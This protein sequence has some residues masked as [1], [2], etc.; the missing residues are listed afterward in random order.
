M[1]NDYKAIFFDWD[2][3]AVEN[4]TADAT[5]VLAA[6]ERLLLAG[7]KLVI[8]SG[9]TYQ[10]ICGGRLEQLL[11]PAAL[12]NLYL[13]LARGNFEYGFD[14]A[15]RR[16]TLSDR[17]PA[18]PALLALHELVFRLHCQLLRENGLPT[19]IYFSRP[20]YCK[21]DL[22]VDS[23]R[24][25]ALFL[26]EGEAERTAALL[27]QHG[28][29][30]GLAALAAQV[31]ALGQQCGTP[32]EVTTDAKYLEIGYS[33]KSTNVDAMLALLAK[34]GIAPADCCFWGDEYGQIAPGIWGSDSLMM[35]ERSRSGDFYSVSTLSLPLPP[36]VQNV[37]GSYHRFIDYLEGCV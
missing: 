32:V 31:T 25:T 16:V 5:R 22:T 33:T 13:G 30:G 1:R 34:D 9:T 29:R 17:T 20:N 19:D 37:G 36:Q 24:S 6:M 26:Q 35:T 12:Q 15:G 14:A 2:G 10:N 3:T 21:L 23:D 8:I 18:T 11:S 4:R 7:K 28:L 27:E